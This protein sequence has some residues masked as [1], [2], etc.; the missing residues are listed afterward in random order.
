VRFGDAVR[1]FRKELGVAIVLGA[2]MALAT[3]VRAWT[4]D[5]GPSVGLVVAVTASCIV[6]WSATVASVLPLV[7]RRLRLD[8]AVVSG[9][10]ITTIVDGTGLVIYFELARWLLH[11]G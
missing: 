10:F 6:L 1:V 3:F 2:I 7:L 4:L 11:L 9:P 5:V 8:P